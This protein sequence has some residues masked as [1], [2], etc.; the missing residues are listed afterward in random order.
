ML[1]V[2]TQIYSL[3]LTAIFF[4]VEYLNTIIQISYD[5]HVVRR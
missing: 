1:K 5:V 3:D 4:D 2:G